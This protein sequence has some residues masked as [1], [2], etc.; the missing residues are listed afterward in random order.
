MGRCDSVR[1]EGLFVASWVLFTAYTT[2]T[3]MLGWLPGLAS[4][5]TNKQLAPL[6]QEHSVDF[7]KL[8]HLAAARAHVMAWDGAVQHGGAKLPENYTRQLQEAQFL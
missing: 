1:C 5:R 8:S 3:A 7:P 4:Y 6:S 2:M